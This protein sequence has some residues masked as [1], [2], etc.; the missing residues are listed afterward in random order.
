MHMNQ[1]DDIKK[2]NCDISC[3][4]FVIQMC[5]IKFKEM[6]LC[7][8]NMLS[9]SEQLCS[10]LWTIYHTAAGQLRVAC[11]CTS[12]RRRPIEYTTKTAACACDKSLM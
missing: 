9:S 5:V 3:H 1:C 12:C 11:R 2:L 10:T 7:N 8:Q 6:F 4:Y